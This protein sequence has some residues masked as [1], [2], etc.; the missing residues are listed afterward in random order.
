MLEDKI[1]NNNYDNVDYGAVFTKSS[2]I[3]VNP[4]VADRYEEALSD[5]VSE[6]YTRKHIYEEL[7]MLYE[8]SEFYS[9]YG[10]DARKIEKRD[11][12]D[13][14]YTFKELLKK[15]HEYSLVQIF[16]AIAEFFEFNY[17]VLYNDVCSLEDKAE[18]LEGLQHLYGLE[19]SLNSSKKLF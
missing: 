7:A 19:K 10:Q 15:K 4:L 18:L 17:K 11:I 9:K 2:S 3:A 16:C 14:Y 6:I 5:D 13:V 1:I 12:S 8:E